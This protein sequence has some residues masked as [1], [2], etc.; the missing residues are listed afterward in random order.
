MVAVDAERILSTMPDATKVTMV[1]LG[2]TVKGVKA[3]LSA[4]HFNDIYGQA[5]EYEF[6]FY[7]VTKDLKGVSIDTGKRATV[8]GTEYLILG[9]QI[10][11]MGLIT[12]IDLGDKFA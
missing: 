7:F 2:K 8:D 1:Y 9:K 12:R 6:S 3:S 4:D 10:D 11:P 5:Q